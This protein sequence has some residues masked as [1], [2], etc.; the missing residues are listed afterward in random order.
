MIRNQ[1]YA[2]LDSNELGNRPFGCLR[3]GERLVLWR[4][5]SG[6][7][8]CHV[9]RCAHRG[10]SLS[11]GKVLHREGTRLMCPFHGLEYDSLGRCVKIPANG[12]AERVPE[13]FRLATYPARDLHGF[14]WIYWADGDA[15]PVEPPRWFGD[16]PDDLS[17]STVADPWAS[18]YS[19]SIENQLDM[20]HL[21]FVHHNSIGR[22]NATVVDGPGILIR[23][24][25]LFVY[26]YN[27]VDDGR[28]RR[29]T[30]EVPAPN[31]DKPLKLEFIFPNV[32]QNYINERLRIVAAFSPVDEG[33]TVVYLRFS[34]SFM[35][36][37]L[38]RSFVHY[39]GDKANLFIAHQDRRVVETQLPKAAGP[40]SGELLFPGDRAI[41]EYRK[42]RREATSGS[43]LDSLPEGRD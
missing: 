40:R 19:R 36:F 20:A 10:A 9:D 5:E 31:P 29:G 26:T 8:V 4:D 2:I 38:L 37:P 1:W 12:A 33:N 11:G 34:Q 17:T 43:A 25:T 3:M 6:K 42:M 22:G 23:D 39:V 30:E 7:P 21:P 15:G 27:R 24:G 14:I 32:W 35:R 28:P 18:H 13:G 41:A 16:L